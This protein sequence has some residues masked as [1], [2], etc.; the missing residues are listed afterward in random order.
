MHVRKGD[1]VAQNASYVGESALR[2]VAYTHDGTLEG[3]LTCIFVAYARKETP[4]DIVAEGAYQP[5]F[6]QSLLHVPTDADKALRVRAGIEREAGGGA[7]NAIMRASLTDD[8]QAGVK[9]LRFVRYAMDKYSGRNKRLNILNDLAN[10]AVADL[11]QLE[12]R[13]NSEAEKMRQF[14]RFSHKENGVWFARCN[15][16]VSVV[17]LVMP[18][19]IARF[20][21]QPFI[22]YDEN[23]H[24]A[25]VYDGYDWQLVPDTVVADMPRA[26]DDAYYEALWQQFYDSLTIEARY[27]P[28]LRRHFMPVRLWKNLPEVRSRAKTPSIVL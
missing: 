21:I 15:P 28:E 13:A 6:G 18:H 5:R 3:L 14:V 11:V 25:G 4:E 9:I 19:L 23:H 2:H 8:P 7:F 20:N 1:I 27:N 17:P 10:P 12:T 22:I 16:N 24:L 26:E